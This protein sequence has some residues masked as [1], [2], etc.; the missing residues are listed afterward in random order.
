MQQLLDRPLC[1]V[2]DGVAAATPAPGGGSSAAVA[3]ALAAGLV[4]MVAGIT[5]ASDDADG[6]MRRL[7]DRAAALRDEAAALGEL[8]L[9][10]YAPVLAAMRRSADDPGRP[11]ALDAA[12]SEAADSPLAIA[13]VA[14][15]V[16]E[17]AVEAARH[18]RP[19]LRG[20]AVTGVLLG[21]AAAAAASRLAVIN[22]EGHP[23]DQ[24]LGE[25]ERLVRDA[26]RARSAV[27]A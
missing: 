1:E 23:G 20:D 18:G 24:R 21:E 16:A 2:L 14:T 12:L 27:L 15:A 5:L 22:L 25:L 10:A 26:A 13:R 8:E 7:H 9:R 3:C 17:L 4:Q 6:E 19:H 11:A